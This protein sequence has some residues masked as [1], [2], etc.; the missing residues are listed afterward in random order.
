MAIDLTMLATDA[1]AIINDLPVSITYRG[2]PYTVTPTEATR[3]QS[4]EFAGLEVSYDVAFFCLVSSF[5]SGVPTQ[6]EEIVYE[7]VTYEIE[8]TIIVQDGKTF[9]MFCRRIA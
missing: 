9:S 3:S 7:G 2:E 4:L 8:R 1:A 5:A 6:N